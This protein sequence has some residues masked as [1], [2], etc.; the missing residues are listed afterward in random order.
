[1]LFFAIS[2]RNN[3]NAKF[4]NDKFKNSDEIN[5]IEFE[6]KETIY[7]ADNM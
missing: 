4:F 6:K 7:K 3:V 5:V 2:V 1:M